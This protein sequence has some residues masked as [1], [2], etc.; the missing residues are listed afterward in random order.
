MYNSVIYLLCGS[1]CRQN[2]DS[3]YQLYNQHEKYVS[4]FLQRIKIVENSSFFQ[5]SIFGQLI[6]Q[7]KKWIR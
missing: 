5:P 2:Q 4:H 7:G 1:F 6:C 3:L